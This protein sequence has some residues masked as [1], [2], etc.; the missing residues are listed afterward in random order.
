MVVVVLLLGE[1]VDLRINLSL[2][3]K[4]R[5]GGV[6]DSFLNKYLRQNIWQ[7]FS[8]LFFSLLFINS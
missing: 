8:V 3:G 6:G 5:R 7:C 4:Q 2:L 1:A